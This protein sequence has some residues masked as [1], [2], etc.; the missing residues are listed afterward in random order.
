MYNI[1]L[2]CG[3]F[4]LFHIGHL[5]IFKKCKQNCHYLIVSILTDEYCKYRKGKY[6]IINQND[7]YSIVE[8]IKYVDKVIYQTHDFQVLDFIRQY[9]IDIV[10]KGSDKTKDP[11]W[12]LFY[13]NELEKL[14]KKLMFFDYTEGIS[15]SKI[16]DKIQN[17]I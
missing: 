13:K 15:T 12:N 5:N 1:G 6:P 16:I 3:V 11:R 10:F 9:N 7:R 14:N 2:T 4:D 8:S 17:K